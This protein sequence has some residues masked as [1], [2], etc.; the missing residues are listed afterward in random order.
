MQDV[1]DQHTDPESDGIVRGGSGKLIC[2]GGYP[3]N[4][5]LDSITIEVLVSTPCKDIIED[6]RSIFRDLYLHVP[7]NAVEDSNVQL[8]LEKRRE[9]EPRVKE[10]REK[11][12]SSKWVLAIMNRHLASRWDVDDDGSLYKTEIQD[13]SAS[14]NRRKCKA[15]DGDDEGTYNRRRRG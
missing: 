6:L 11:L 3:L 2:L 4:T 15:A 10:A 7:A 12:R 14:R 13:L 5:Y 9:Q 8:R 1:F